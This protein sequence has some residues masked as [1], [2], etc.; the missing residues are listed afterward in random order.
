M[1]PSTKHKGSSSSLRA[2]TLAALVASLALLPGCNGQELEKFFEALVLLAIVLVVLHLIVWGAMVLVI[3]MNLVHLGRGKPSLGWGATSIALGAVTGA[4][5][6]LSL[7]EHFHAPT[8]GSVLLSVALCFLGYKNVAG[9]RDLARWR[10][11][12]GDDER[13]GT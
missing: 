2:A 4:P 10:K 8:L 7:V 13:S 1:V 11:L 12:G 5:Q 6:I 9:A 3:V